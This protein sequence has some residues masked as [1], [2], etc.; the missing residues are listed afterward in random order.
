M[1]LFK[2]IH[3]AG[4]NI[5]QMPCWLLE[6]KNLC[7]ENIHSNNTSIHLMSLM[8]DI[9]S[10]NNRP[11]PSTIH[12]PRLAA[13]CFINI[14]NGTICRTSILM[15]HAYRRSG[16]SNTDKLILRAWVNEG[17][18]MQASNHSNGL[19]WNRWDD[20]WKISARQCGS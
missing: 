4:C 2:Y 11:P 9:T 18:V 17:T 10:V 1:E 12:P 5:R 8:S 16:S 13:A 3:Q 20:V 6:R 7:F 14:C 15:L 19:E